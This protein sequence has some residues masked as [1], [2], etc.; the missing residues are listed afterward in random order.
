MAPLTQYMDI[1]TGNLEQITPDKD[2]VAGGIQSPDHKVQWSVFCQLSCV[3]KKEVMAVLTST[4]SVDIKTDL[5][6]CRLKVNRCKDWIDTSVTYANRHVIKFC[7][8]LAYSKADCLSSHLKQNS[9]GLK[10]FT[11]FYQTRKYFHLA[12]LKSVVSVWSKRV[13]R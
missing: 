13:T 8:L 5:S 12:L 11:R 1:G 2:R 9:A 10:S 4:I 3:A 6:L 7:M